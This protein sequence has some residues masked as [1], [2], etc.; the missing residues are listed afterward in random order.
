[1]RHYPSNLG[2]M[3]ENKLVGINSTRHGKWTSGKQLNL[4]LGDSFNK[5]MVTIR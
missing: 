1:M 2:L 4:D 5:A 3:L